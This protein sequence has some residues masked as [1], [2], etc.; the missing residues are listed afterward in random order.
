MENSTSIVSKP[1]ALRREQIRLGKPLW[2]R[3]QTKKNYPIKSNYEKVPVLDHRQLSS[4]G[5]TANNKH[6]ACNSHGNTW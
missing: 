6:R 2:R 5:R 4:L 1:D 3:H